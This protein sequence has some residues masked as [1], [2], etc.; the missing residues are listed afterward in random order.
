[1][2]ERGAMQSSFHPSGLLT[3]TTDFGTSGPYI[4]VLKGVIY[5][6]FPGA[7][8]V[9]LTHEVDANWPAEAGFWIAQTFSHFPTGTVHAAVVEA[10]AR[11]PQLGLAV[12][13]LGHAFVG[14]DNGLLAQVAEEPDAVVY[15][16]EASTLKRL[17]QPKASPTFQ[18]KNI[19]APIAAAMA[20]GKLAPHEIGPVLQ[21]WVPS[22]LEPPHLKDASLCGVVVT[23][24]GFGNIVTNISKQHLSTFPAAEV[25]I[26]KKTIPIKRN[27]SEGAPGDVLAVTNA[28]GFLEIARVQQSAAGYLGVGRGAPITIRPRFHRT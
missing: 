14:P 28:F 10:G 23:I 16:I 18:G 9:D 24:D 22:L 15:S 21:D 13:Y 5:E 17:G 12:I 26:G 20:S 2:L 8:I 25:V 3:I 4:G 6:S 1:M 7:Q 27:Y 11:S 19:Q